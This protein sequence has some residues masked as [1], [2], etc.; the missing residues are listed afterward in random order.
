MRT[1]LCFIVSL[2]IYCIGY[3]QSISP[4]GPVNLCPLGNQV[5]SVTGAPA[6]ATYIWTESTVP[7]PGATNPTYTANAAGTYSVIINGAPPLMPVTVIMNSSPAAGF[8][9][10]P[11]GQC[12]NTP[13][14]F[15]NTSTGSGLTYAWTF[16]DAASGGNNTSTQA[17]PIHT[18]IG[19]NGN[20]NQNFTVT[21]TVTSDMGCTNSI[22]HTVTTSQ[23]PNINMNGTG[24]TTYNGITYF[25]SCAN[26]AATLT[27]INASTTSATN[28]NYQ[29]I[30]GDAS[31]DFNAATMGAT[32]HAYALGNYPL[33]FIVTGQNGCKDTGFYRVFVGSNPAIGFGTNGNT[34]ICS[35]SSL[36][37]NITG[38]GANSPS[39][40][41]TVTFNDGSSPTVFSHPPPDSIIHQFLHTSCGTNSGTFANSFSTSIAASN[42][43]LSSVISI[44]PIYVTQ[45]PVASF[46]ISPR[47]TVCVNT[48]VTVTNTSPLN[49]DNNNGTCL[50]GKFV[51]IITPSTGYSLGGSLGSQFGSDPDLWVS[52][53]NSLNLNFT[54]PGTYTIKL[55]TGNHNCGTDSM[56][57]TICVNPLPT[58]SFSIDQSTGCAPLTVNTTT[59]STQP[60]CGSNSYFW[61]VTY[62]STTGCNPAVSSVTYLGGTS[63]TSAQPIF[64][65][66]NPGVYTINMWVISAAASC[67]TQVVSQQVIVKGKPVVALGALPASI[68]NDQSVSPSAVA[69]CYTT[70]ATYAWSFP[71]ATPATSSSLNPGTIVYNTAGPQTIS[72]SV[73]N[74][75]GT[76]T[77]TQNIIVK[78]TPDVITP[79]N[80]VVCAG[81]V[82]GPLTLTSGTPGATFNW[83]N[84]NTAIGLAA[85]GSSAAIPVFTATN[86]TASP[87]TATISGTATL[88]GCSSGASF[89]ITVNPKPPLPV[90]TTPVTYCQNVV[91]SPLSATATAGNT[92][93]WYTTAT[94]GTGSATVPVPSTAATGTT[95]YYVSQQNSTT[96]CEGPR[97]QINV[98]INASPAISGSTFVNPN[99]CSAAT[100][101][102]TLS[103]LANSVTYTVHYT[104]NSVAQTATIT[105][106]A[107]GTL[108]IPNLVA[109]SYDNINVTVLGCPSNNVGPVTLSDPAAPSAPVAGNSGPVCSGGT[110]NLTSTVAPAGAA[111]N[112]SGPAGYISHVQNPVISPVVTTA[113]GTYTLSLSQS[114]CT[115]PASVTVVVVNQ[116]PATPSASNNGPVCVGNPLNLS[117]STTFAGAVNWSWTGPNG[118]TDAT[119]NPSIPSVTLAAAGSYSV[120]VTSVTGTCISA[121][122]ATT[123]TV[124]PTPSIAGAVAANPTACSSATGSITLS[125]LIASSTYT[126]T[127]T[128]NS[129]AQTAS[130]SSNASGVLIIP[131]LV[132]GTYDNIK[133]TLNGCPSTPVGPYTLSDPN[134]PADPVAGNSGPLCSGGNLTLTSST[135]PAGATYNWSGPGGYSSS[136][137][138]PVITG[139]T[140]SASGIYS[141]SITLNACTSPAVTTTV[142]VN[143]T[144]PAPAASNNGPLCDGNALNL[145]A[146]TTFPGALTWLWSGPNSFSNTSQNPSIPVATLAA[147]GLYTVVATAVTGAC[148]SPPGSTTV[149]VKPT[150]HISSGAAVN[151]SLCASATGSITLSGLIVS[152]NYTVHYTFNSAAQ[153]ATLSSDINGNLIIPNLAAGAYDNISV[154]LNGCTSNA[155]GPFTLSDPNP[156]VM[157]GIGSDGPVCSGQTLHLT[158]TNSSPGTP[159]FTWSGPNGFTSASATP[160]VTNITTAASGTYTVTVTIAGCISPAASVL[161]L[162]DST[163]VRPV[164]ASNGPVCSDSTINLFATTASPGAMT[165][166]WSGP[167][168]F[169]SIVQNPAIPNATVA[170]NGT[171]SVTA[172]A[173]Q[174]SCISA[175]GTNLVVVNPTPVIASSAFTNP[176][177][178]NSA[179]GSISLNVSQFNTAYTVHYLQGGNP[180][181][182]TITSSG[183]GALLIPGLPAGI[184]SNIYVVL[185]GCRSLAAGPF[186]L[187]DPNPPAAP[188]AG[189]N[190]AVCSGQTLNLNASTVATGTPTWSWTGPNGF[191]SVIQNPS[192]AN[193]TAASAGSYFVTVTIN[194]CT[195]P[196]TTVPVIV[197]PLPAAPVVT[198]PVE[199]CIGMPSVPLTATPAPGN[200]LNWYTI[201][202]GGTG[203]QTA[204]IP[205][206]L[207]TGTTSYYV[208]QTNSFGCEGPRDTI[209]VIVHPDAIAQFVPTDTIGCP[210]FVLTPAVIGLQTF[211][212]NN[213]VYEWYANNVFIG[214]GAVFPGYTIL[215][216]NSTVTIKLK[217]ISLFGCKADSMSRVFNTYN[218]PHPTF[219][220][221]DTVGCGPLAVQV[222]NTSANMGLFT[223]SWN[224]GNGQTSPLQQPGTITFLPNP[225]YNDTIYHVSLQ[226]FSICDTITITRDVRVKSKPKA[227][228][229]PSITTGCSPMTVTFQNT[230][231]G[232]NSTYYWDFGDGATL[233]NNT[234]APVQHTYNTG[235]Q[236]TFYVRLVAVNECGSDTIQYSLIAAPNNIFLNFAVNGPD[237]FGCAPHMVAFINNTSG[238]STFSWNFGDG[239]ILSTTAGIDTVYHTYLTAGNFTVTLHAFNS[240]TDTTT[241]DFI[242]V[243]A[244]PVA[245]FTADNYTA[246]QG[247]PVTFTN[248]ST[249]GTSYLW[250]F[251]DGNT[252]TLAIPIHVY[253]SPGLYTVQLT[254]FSANAPGNVCNDVVQQQV[255]VVSSLPGN[256]TMSAVSAPCAP[257]TVTFV[258]QNRP[259]VTSNWTFGDGG[260]ATG[261]SV[262]HTY[263]TPGVYNV[264]LTVTIPGGCTYNT[265]HV[266]TVNGPGGSLIYTGGYTCYPYPVRLEA[267]GTGFNN[268]LWDFGDGTTLSTTL[269]VVFHT[270]AN[271]G[272]YIP[273]V[274]LQNT[275]GCNFPVTGTDTI[276]VDKI[277]AGYTSAQQQYCGYTRINFN[278]TS[279]VFF[280]TTSIQWNFGDGNN[281]TGASPVH[282]YMIT[283][284]YTV[285]MII[286]GV[287]GCADTISHILN[288]QV[289]SKPVTAISGPAVKCT[290]ESVTFNSSITSIDPITFMQWTI[291]GGGTATGA[292]LIHTFTTAGTYT[293]R[294]IAGTTNG[295]FD[296][297]FHTIIINQSPVVT[298]SPNVTI[299]LGN[300]TTLTA[301]GGATYQW[302]PLQGLSCTTCANPVANPVITTPYVV[303]GTNALGCSIS[304]PV[305]VTV[306]QP[307]NMMVSPNDT[308]CILQSANL[309]ATGA[310][311]YAWSP[312]TGLSSTTVS[313]PVAAPLITT[314][315]RVVG[316]DGFNCFTDTAFVLVAV[317]QYPTV[318]LG[319]DLTL[320]AGTVHPLITTV[321][322][323]PVQS[324][325]WTPTADLNCSTCPLPNATIKKDITYIVNIKNI[326][327]CAASD[328]V[329]IKVFCENSQVFIPNA[330]TPDGDGINDIL[331]VRGSGIA[332]VKSFRIFNRWG[333][334]VFEK[335]SFPPNSVAYGWNGKIKG[336]YGPPDV[337]V[338]TA[339]VI[340]ENGTSFTYKGNVSIIK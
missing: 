50:P 173:V 187:T 340:C 75:C 229:T 234:H 68:C 190:S 167:N 60:L 258:N 147:G 287:S 41:Y 59:V 51:W 63:N 140:V 42:P 223:Y 77:V 245:A 189:S 175:A 37:F 309:I 121:A 334:V 235:V 43:C 252:S 328:T 86:I 152:S 282:D 89:T 181:T 180:Q 5:L 146:T 26:S 316:Y 97:A 44:V 222:I 141:L 291:S 255:Q 67:S 272:A 124:R 153:T 168:G 268:L 100:G 327:G 293:I 303:T 241:T 40:V 57:R 130:L 290:G 242:H 22:S 154:V 216:E 171:Y 103:G 313:N 294:F 108:I 120:T 179:T 6:G 39:T 259:S 265:S 29:I 210:P 145:T 94:G 232:L 34:A 332:M 13:V 261:D 132:A 55:I 113:A 228:F 254:V 195:S 317:G 137:Q 104:F 125:G 319:P 14:F 267:T 284:N 15:T 78:P 307:L 269:Q 219:N 182:I 212:A 289:K 135:A 176:S 301:A 333:E 324:W 45:K 62:A 80:I 186:T 209:R 81:T 270:Y 72:L 286:N 247:L 221:I 244:K 102:I 76:T 73:T 163:P 178:C 69:S 165:W 226:V 337:F 273:H 64:Q 70:S 155:V 128:F 142:I 305:T 330:F 36:T 56:I 133:V 197:H 17:N 2:C 110:L 202:T 308:I 213:G 117:A 185:S 207:V 164:I 11:S 318:N 201:A 300:S 123:V 109:G 32:T 4:A 18:F 283:G 172:T 8:T 312:A 239:N 53:S 320:A 112:W 325:I 58:G 192:I 127:Y 93:L 310:T 33:L 296:T 159:T 138:N 198:T 256:F 9:F 3:S 262:V 170:A 237:H 114:G 107:A 253:P 99:A 84:S 338:Y 115:S 105:S 169:T 299:C 203:T 71:G 278:D 24:M 160:A 136:Q 118:F 292:N 218:L 184:Y 314:M 161:V 280:G 74:E 157:P 23:I 311:T 48:N 191:T 122:A 323:G 297:T 20:G 295:C 335:S 95:A 87:I 227:L 7:I 298:V 304:V 238:A 251:G 183:S 276:K 240:C 306:I 83:T 275:A 266:V 177:L 260:T 243:F 193:T 49:S 149:T 277:D 98:T 214:T 196:Q 19:T 285:Q 326:Y 208:S 224:F 116:T 106:T 205:S 28:T 156:P 101:S 139:A 257:L 200:P 148:P 322:N 331:M 144:P 230:S 27:F 211:P 188:V 79:A 329:N 61:T 134:P 225:T 279:H 206:T 85:T 194:N 54:V 199:Y 21:L 150:P 339:E 65:F 31:P 281:G 248:Q 82:V 119:Q 263:T 30:W 38:Y 166:S 151:P 10:S 158:A 246:C 250:N 321:V 92:L 16:G 111:Y 90:V 143:Q 12:S 46:S 204:P 274:T 336:V 231:L 91:A 25:T 217:A 174:G 302:S 249:G 288:V 264:S 52:G 96:G 162:I 271:A 1:L 236:D 220:L 88:N 47:D 131:N 35:N 233:V 129:I 215:N 66:N 315:Y 126:V